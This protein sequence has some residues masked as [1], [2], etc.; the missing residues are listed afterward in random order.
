MDLKV[1]YFLIYLQ[2]QNLSK[3][4]IARKVATLKSFFRFMEREGY[5]KTSL[6]AS[7]HMPRFD[8]TLPEFLSEDEIKNVIT[9]PPAETFEG[10]RDRAILE[11][12][13]GC[14][15][16]L[17]ELINLKLRDLHLSEN[18][19]RVFGKGKKERIAPVGRSSKRA[20]DNYLH[21]RRKY[22]QAE[23]ENLFILK[24]GKPLYP[25]AVQR[26]VKKYIEMAVNCSKA[27]PHMLRHS[28][29]T[30]LLNAGANIRAV[31]DLLGHENL[32]TT[33]VY[34]HLSIEHLK[35]V[36]RKFHK[37]VKINQ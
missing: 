35:N 10:I 7:I 18:V 26:L 16:R 6:S 36:Y 5:L 17:S 20:I 4:S 37:P 28:Y 1:K 15:L 11:L 32:S 33:Q 12:F 25:M 30:H 9:Q 13:Y 19:I 27:N 23:V 8:K 24:S 31:K 34:T 29:A 21:Y 14:G 2:E 22:A 3:R